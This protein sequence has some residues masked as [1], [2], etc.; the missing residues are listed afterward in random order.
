MRFLKFCSVLL[1]M[2]CGYPA[3]KDCVVCSGSL[4][5]GC[6]CVLSTWVFSSTGFS[7]ARTSL[8]RRNGL[9][10][11][12]WWFRENMAQCSLFLD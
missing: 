12:N 7:F 2:V 6:T 8:C 9:F 11:Y 4:A 3:G 1:N 5:F 10:L